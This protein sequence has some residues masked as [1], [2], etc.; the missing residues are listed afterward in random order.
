METRNSQT[1]SKELPYNFY[2]IAIG[3][4]SRRIVSEI[5]IEWIVS[6]SE[7]L[8]QEYEERECEILTICGNQD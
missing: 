8:H 2:P 7:C 4:R 5:V 3:H 1:S 6:V